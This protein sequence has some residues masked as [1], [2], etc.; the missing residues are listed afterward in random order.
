MKSA[1]RYLVGAVVAAVLGGVCLAGGFLER[2]MARAQ[3][4]WLCRNTERRTSRS[5]GPSAIS[6]MAAAFPGWVP[7][8]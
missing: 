8:C 6:S 7:A 3:Q 2:D 5:R 1:I 4:R